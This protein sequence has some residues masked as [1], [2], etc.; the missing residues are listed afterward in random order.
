MQ[1]TEGPAT[2]Q[3]FLSSKIYDTLKW[4]TQILLPAAG[5]LYFTLSGIWG[6][7]AGQQVVG[8]ITAVVLFLGLVLNV[9]SKLYYNSDARF[10]GTI[11]VHPDD[12]R[13]VLHLDDET[14]LHHKDE[15]T[16]KVH[17][18]HKKKIPE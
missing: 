13:G 8:S 5:T 2:T 10:S 7:P 11:D 15:V 14:D 9:N 17:R 18:V 16:F 1:K 3:P 12:A 6:L 4:V